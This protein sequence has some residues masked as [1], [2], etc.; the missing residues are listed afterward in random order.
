MLYSDIFCVPFSFFLYP[1]QYY[2]IGYWAN[3]RS[4]MMRI[5]TYATMGWF[6]GTYIGIVNNNRVG[7]AATIAYCA[8]D[9]IVKVP[10]DSCLGH[11]HSL[12]V[13]PDRL[14]FEQYLITDDR[15]LLIKAYLI[16][17]YWPI[18]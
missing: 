9:M 4:E 1:A 5:D 6:R 12:K 14:S 3:N 13:I 17:A 11:Q 18:Q 15:Y 2:L 10:I 16:D 7:A 8:I